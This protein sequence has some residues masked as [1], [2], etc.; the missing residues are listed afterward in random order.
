MLKSTVTPNALAGGGHMCIEPLHQSK[1][2]GFLGVDFTKDVC[3]YQ[4][5]DYTLAP[6]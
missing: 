5:Y 4:K 1:H 3:T 2:G 6:M